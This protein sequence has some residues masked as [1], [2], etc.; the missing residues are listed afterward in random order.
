MHIFKINNKH[1]LFDSEST[2]WLV[3]DEQSIDSV[4]SL[5][6]DPNIK[7]LIELSRSYLR[8]L[9]NR[10]SIDFIELHVTEMCNLACDYCYIPPQMRNKDK[11]LSA[12]EIDN[13]LTKI[14]NF[15]ESGEIDGYKRV[16]FHGGEPWIGKKSIME[17]VERYHRE[18]E[19]MLQTN[20]T[21]ISEDDA[22]FL[23]RYG[24]FVGISL[25]GAR[26]DV[27]DKVRFYR[28]G[29]GTWKRVVETLR[30]FKGYDRLSVTVTLTRHNVSNLQD[31]VKFLYNEGVSAALINPVSP[32]NDRAEKY[33][34]SLNEL[35]NNFK[36][37]IDLLINLNVND[38]KFIVSNVESIVLSLVTFNV[39]TMYCNMSPCG[40]GRLMWVIMS[41]GDVYPC[42]EFVQFSEF[43]CGNIFRDSIRSIINSRPA[44]M[45]RNRNVENIPRCRNCPFKYIC[46]ANCP[47]PLWYRYRDIFRPSIYCRFMFEIIKYILSKII[48]NPDTVLSLVSKKFRRYIRNIM[49]TA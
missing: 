33:V 27:H 8:E 9:S 49:E 14:F 41:N 2:F 25:D 3:I 18:V 24:V 47:V 23:M 12:E 32:C 31:I 17:I 39:R 10:I 21:L 11:I 1:I 29:E 36:E 40:A 42:S 30:Y 20:G 45:L 16:V 37:M 13:I 34:P 19:F 26:P 5:R 22:K 44:E 4:D 7:K 46:G 35:I 43:R 28:N 6:D 48:E 15:I 38:S